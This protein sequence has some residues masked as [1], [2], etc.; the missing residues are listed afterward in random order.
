MAEA[1]ADRGT[2]PV[3]MPLWGYALCVL[4]AVVGM[5]GLADT[6]VVWR[7]WFDLAVKV[8][9]RDVEQ[10]VASAL[11]GFL[12]FEPPAQ[13]L[14]YALVGLGVAPVFLTGALA[15][16]AQTPERKGRDLD[17]P[18]RFFACLALALVWPVVVLHVLWSFSRGGNV[19]HRRSYGER[20]YALRSQYTEEGRLSRRVTGRL[21]SRFLL[22]V[23]VLCAAVLGA[24]ADPAATLNR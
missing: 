1:D 22:I 20:Y 12:P 3:A 21:M 9:W 4:L 14:D 18:G 5:I 15:F 10:A 24:A 17:G 8:P 7:E 2:D 16:P 6:V 23:F 11:M 13:I 19:H